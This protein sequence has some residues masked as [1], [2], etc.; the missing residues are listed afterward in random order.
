MRRSA[1]VLGKEGGVASLLGGV[2]NFQKNKLGQKENRI[3]DTDPSKD[4]GHLIKINRG[5]KR[6][7]KSSAL[8]G[9]RKSSFFARKEGTTSRKLRG[10]KGAL[11]SNCRRSRW[12]SESESHSFLG[13]RFAP[14]QPGKVKKGERIRD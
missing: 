8:V 12:I 6:S 7:S 14:S 1:G 3:L 13:L 9:V 4:Y 10:R 2:Q 11:F 5:G